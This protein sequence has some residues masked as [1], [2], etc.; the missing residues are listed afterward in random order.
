M[1]A[2]TV[3][4]SDRYMLYSP[5]GMEKLLTDTTVIS[6]DFN[7]NQAL[8]QGGFPRD[9][10]WMGF[11]WRASTRLPITGTIRSMFAYQKLG[12]GIA[13]GNVPNASRIGERADK[14]YSTQVYQCLVVGATRIEEVAVV[15]IDI[16]ENL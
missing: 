4:M 3:L 15:Q 5:A 10:V 9:Q 2:A 14:N 13:T 7:T 16:D 12:M 1:N 11:K 6:S 8:V